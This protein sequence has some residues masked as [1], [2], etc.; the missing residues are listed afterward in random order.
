[1]ESSSSLTRFGLGVGGTEMPLDIS[2]GFDGG[3][4]SFGGE[5]GGAGG[6]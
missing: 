4:G 2:M 6:C 3:G 1:L 5:E